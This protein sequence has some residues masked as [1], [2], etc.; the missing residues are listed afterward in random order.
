MPSRGGAV[1]AG[2]QETSGRKKTG[3]QLRTALRKPVHSSQPALWR[4]CRSKDH[5]VRD[6]YM[7]IESRG[8]LINNVNVK[9]LMTMGDTWKR[10]FNDRVARIYPQCKKTC[11]KM[12]VLEDTALTSNR[13][14]TGS[15]KTWVHLLTNWQEVSIR[16]PGWAVQMEIITKHVSDMD[17]CLVI[18]HMAQ[19]RASKYRRGRQ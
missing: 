10:A 13:H 4:I 6:L 5:G 14:D 15:V 16:E 18:R 17:D 3:R 12:D 11:P 8:N 19:R 9:A 7:M 1:K 2:R